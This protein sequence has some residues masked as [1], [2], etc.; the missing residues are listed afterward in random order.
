MLGEEEFVSDDFKKFV[1][2]VESN[3]K[4][5][6]N[7]VGGA[8]DS[9]QEGGVEGSDQVEG[10]QGSD[11]ALLVLQFNIWE[12]GRIDGT[13]MKDRLSTFVS[14]ALWDVVTELHLLPRELTVPGSGH[15]A[16]Q[17]STLFSNFSTR[18]VL[19]LKVIFEPITL[20]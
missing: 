12:Q 13:M 17:L 19:V 16:P 15:S 8:Q 7:Q 11:P 3:E 9:D 18:S 14:H 6:I 10:A 1:A 20:I 2:V 5:V 4:A